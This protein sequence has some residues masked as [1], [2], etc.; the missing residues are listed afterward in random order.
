L[1]PS[2]AIWWFFPGFGAI[3]LSWVMM[4]L[5]LPFVLGKDTAQV[6]LYWTNAR[7]GLN[8]SK[9]FRWGA[10]LVAGPIGFFTVLALPVHT[11]FLE[12]RI[13]FSPYASVKAKTYSYHQIRGLATTDGIRDRFGKFVPDPCILIDF[14]D[15][16]RWSSRDLL[17]DPDRGIDDG[18]KMFLVAR[19]R[20]PVHHVPLRRTFGQS[21]FQRES[22]RQAG[23]L[24]DVPSGRQNRPVGHGL[25][26]APGH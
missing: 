19:G 7:A 9:F 20:T 22:G 8:A 6:Y 16:T 17:R 4:E 23:R 15:G 24:A 12:D 3:T 26:L 21:N 14:E 2:Q 13:V 18:L 11:S 1:Y 5:L 10:L 25:G